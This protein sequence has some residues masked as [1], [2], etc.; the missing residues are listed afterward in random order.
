MHRYG[1]SGKMQTTK[2][3]ELSDGQ[4]VSAGWSVV[5][6]HM[7]RAMRDVSQPVNQARGL[8]ISSLL[9]IM[10]AVTSHFRNDVHG[11]AKHGA[12]SLVALTLPILSD[13]TPMTMKFALP[14]L[15]SSCLL[16]SPVPSV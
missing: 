9:S 10:F 15:C 5:H 3:A 1:V 2:I 7:Q 6:G 14:L 11:Q 13:R 16:A 8:G 4:K 12:P